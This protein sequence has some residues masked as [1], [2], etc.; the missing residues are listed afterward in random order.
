MFCIDLTCSQLCSSHTSC[1]N[2]RLSISV[3][4]SAGLKGAT[5]RLLYN[6]FQ[7]NPRSHTCCLRSLEP[8]RP[9]RFSGFRYISRFAKS[10]ASKDQSSGI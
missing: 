6:E 8:L 4:M 3:S 7:S 5:A 9:N 10:A 2:I 1:S